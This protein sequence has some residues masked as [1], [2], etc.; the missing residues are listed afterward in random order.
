MRDVVGFEGRYG[1]TSCGKVWSYRRKRFLHTY[2][3]DDYQ[4]VCL[5]KD[6]KSYFDYVHRLVA[7]AYLPN[8]DNLP[9]VNHK[10][11]VRTHNWLNNLEWCTR[12]Y[13][14]HYSNIWTKHHSIAVYCVE[15]DKTYE[16]I[17][18][19]AKETG[20]HQSNLSTLLKNKNPEKYTL[21]GYHFRYA[22]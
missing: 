15:L 21:G 10:D 5:F 22:N 19:A 1:I 14:L 17:K 9:D 20:V 4:M 8:P 7:K 18:V 12:H 11:E 2:G 6:G 16:S 3:G 13:N